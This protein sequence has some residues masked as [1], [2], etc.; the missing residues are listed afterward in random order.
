MVF[1]IRQ[2]FFYRVKFA[3]KRLMATKIVGI[4]LVKQTALIISPSFIVFT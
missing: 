4:V 1:F 2:I 3:D